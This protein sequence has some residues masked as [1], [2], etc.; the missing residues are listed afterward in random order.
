MPLR[1]SGWIALAMAL[2]TAVPLAARQTIRA[3]RI[4]APRNQKAPEQ[5][6][7]KAPPPPTTHP[8]QR[9]TEP[10]PLRKEKKGWHPV[11]VQHDREVPTFYGDPTARAWNAPPAFGA[12]L[13]MA[14]RFRAV[15]DEPE[16]I[17]DDLLGP[18][19]L[20]RHIR[21]AIREH[22][23]KRYFEKL[24]G[25]RLLEQYRAEKALLG[26]CPVD[27]CEE[28]RFV[29]E[30]KN[31]SPEGYCRE[32]AEQFYGKRV[33]W[34]LRATAERR[35][36]RETQRRAFL[37]RYHTGGR[38]RDGSG[39]TAS[40]Q[41]ADRGAARAVLGQAP[42]PGDFPRPGDLGPVGTLPPRADP[43]DPAGYPFDTV[44]PDQDPFARP[45]EERTW[46]GV[47]QRAP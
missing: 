3:S 33:D 25:V 12:G 6:M 26:L 43:R 32:H 15:R 17:T 24:E 45:G 5:P 2:A 35:E 31:F 19:G 34:S 14:Q 10:L 37:R 38:F 29:L 22:R 21:G 42:L 9:R 1:R 8:W 16:S 4:R 40:G 7:P 47:S 23:S 28:P 39:P 18:G 36:F 11:G 27:A 20:K 13:P 46:W 44:D 30:G 41:G